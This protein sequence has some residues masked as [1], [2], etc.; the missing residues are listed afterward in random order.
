MIW[1]GFLFNT[2]LGALIGIVMYVSSRLFAPAEEN[3]GKDLRRHPGKY[4]RR[5]KLP[6]L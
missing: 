3:A 6:W 4:N 5:V 2:W 1:F